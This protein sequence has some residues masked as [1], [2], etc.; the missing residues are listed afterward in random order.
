MQA[1]YFNGRWVAP[2]QARISA[3]D[4]GFLF[5]DGVYEVIPAFKRRLFGAEAHLN[6]LTRSLEQIDIQDP[7]TRVQ[8]LDVINRLVSDC[9]SVDVSIYIQVTRGAPAKRDHAYPDPPVPPTVLASASAISPLSAKIRTHGAKAITV[10]DLRWGRCDIKS[11]NLLPNIMARQQAVAAG[12]VE[13]I[14]VRE[15]IALE[16]AASN[17]FAVIDDDLLTAPL[18]PHI[19]GGVTRNRLADMVKD[20]GHIPLLES[21]IPFDRLFDATEVF[22]T[23]STRDLLP[24]TRINEHPVGTGRIGPVWTE[25]SQA[26]TKLKQQRET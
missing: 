11:V 1:V 24:I 12:A 4:R 9:P 25:L 21:P 26:F 23:S 5:G 16:G 6:R 17:L 19:L 22:M 15:G 10:P 2:E 20:Q 18:G 3:F 8:W 13:A 14:M 7:L